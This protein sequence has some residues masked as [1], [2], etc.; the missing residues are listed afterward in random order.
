[1]LINESRKILETVVQWLQLTADIIYSRR[2]PARIPVKLS[3]KHQPSDA[4]RRKRTL[5]LKK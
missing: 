5:R 2:Q 3:N 4:E 1:M